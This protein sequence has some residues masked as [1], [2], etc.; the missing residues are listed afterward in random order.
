MHISTVGTPLPQDISACLPNCSSGSSVSSSSFS[1]RPLPYH[2]L[3]THPPLSFVCRAVHCCYLCDR[4]CCRTFLFTQVLPYLLRTQLSGQLQCLL[5]PQLQG[6]PY[7]LLLNHSYAIASKSFSLLA[8]LWNIFSKQRRQ[9]Q[10][11]FLSAETA[12]EPTVKLDGTTDAFIPFQTAVHRLS[13]A[14]MASRHRRGPWSNQEDGLLM[15]LVK[16]HGPLNWVQIAGTIGSRSPKQC[17]ERYHQNLKPTLNHEP[18]T[19]EEGAEIERLVLLKGKRWAEIARMLNGRSD[20]A[21]KNWW[22]G[23]QNRRKRQGRKR[24]GNQHEDAFPNLTTASPFIHSHLAASPSPLPLPAA[25]RPGYHT[26]AHAYGF[27][28][29]YAHGQ[30]HNHGQGF[31]HVQSHQPTMDHP[32]P[33]PCSSDS[34]DSEVASEYTTSPCHNLRLQH[35]PV[36][37]PPLR[38]WLSARRDDGQLPS[39]RALA[40][41]APLSHDQAPYKAGPLPTSSCS[42]AENQARDVSPLYAL[43][44]APNSPENIQ[45]QR[46]LA[47]ETGRKDARMRL[48]ALLG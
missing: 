34:T 46:Y 31:S 3:L 39:C 16:A 45:Q 28:P 35:T 5:I 36:E 6:T 8:S 43:P 40:T 30:S 33:S 44:T 17:R 15:T 21:V 9:L 25:S 4:Q 22:N 2:S 32:L 13:Q 1:H 18:I 37:L 12:G 41:I 7:C 42:H 20:N 47:E 27:S 26:S 19:P 48:S 24:A 29:G 11:C 14:P 23:N 38:V 10:E